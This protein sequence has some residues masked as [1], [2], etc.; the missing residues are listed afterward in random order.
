MVLQSTALGSII[1]WAPRDSSRRP[2]RRS[3]GVVGVRSPS[4][5]RAEPRPLCALAV[6]R[7]RASRRRAR[8][9][10]GGLG[11]VLVSAAARKASS[12]G[13]LHATLDEPRSRRSRGASQNL[14]CRPQRIIAR[15]IRDGAQAA[16]RKDESPRGAARGAAW[17]QATGLGRAQHPAAGLT[18][19]RDPAM[20]LPD[21]ARPL[22]GSWRA[23]LPRWAPPCRGRRLEDGNVVATRAQTESKMPQ[24]FELQ[25]VA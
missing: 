21:A 22:A 11:T 25:R 4:P 14:S 10:E 16:R 12:N 15:A 9:C 2:G 24:C 17:G 8:E 1:H 19:G 20:G 7:E 3:E 13:D 18:A 5:G 6:V 23:G